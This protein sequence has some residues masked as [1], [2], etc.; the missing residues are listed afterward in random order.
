MMCRE[1]RLT[2]SVLNRELPFA[3]DFTSRLSYLGLKF[4]SSESTIAEF[5]CEGP[6]IAALLGGGDQR[7]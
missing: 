4:I 3:P 7:L 5:F 1:N 2:H 6:V